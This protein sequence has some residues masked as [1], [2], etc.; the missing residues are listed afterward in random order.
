MLYKE[1]LEK[2]NN[3]FKITVWQL[4]SINEV[5]SFFSK[6]DDK[7]FEH[8]CDFVYD[9]IINSDMQSYE[10]CQLIQDCINDKEFTWNDFENN[11]NVIIDK[12]NRRI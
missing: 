11:W 9:W 6:L 5:A 7:T 8:V 12:I 4:V 2:F 1:Q 10:L 3:E